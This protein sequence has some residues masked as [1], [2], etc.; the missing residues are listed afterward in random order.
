[1]VN[2]LA[3]AKD[4]LDMAIA[5]Q[6]DGTARA[7][8]AD[9]SGLKA[10]VEAMEFQRMFAGSMDSHNAFVDIQSGA[11]GT[12]AQDWAEKIGRAHV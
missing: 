3:E 10:K 11:G 1:M 9:V 6:D 5:E 4:L 12:E 2:A 8:D 7:V